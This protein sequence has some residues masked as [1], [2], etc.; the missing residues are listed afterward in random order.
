M[1]KIK[2]ISL[3]LTMLI[4]FVGFSQQKTITGTVTKGKMGIPGVTIK[5]KDSNNG[6]LTDINGSFTIKASVGDT[7]VFNFIGFDEQ[8]IRVK[9]KTTHL[10]IELKTNATQLKEV[11]DDPIPKKR[12]SETRLQISKT[13]IE[14]RQ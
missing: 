8:I 10:N 5:I 4:C 2:L 11:Y 3:A 14:K 9:K 1:K 7:L 13:A 6:T 12:N